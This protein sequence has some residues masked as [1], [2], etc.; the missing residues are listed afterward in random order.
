MPSP[1]EAALTEILR[2][3]GLPACNE[4]VVAAYMASRGAYVREPNASGF[5]VTLTPEEFAAV[6]AFWSYGATRG[7]HTGPDGTGPSPG[8]L[9]P[10]L[11]RM[12]DAMRKMYE[13]NR[14]A[15]LARGE[16]AA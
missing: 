9:T 3:F 4:D 15:R 12:G 6:C 11:D 16:A 13:A 2:E 7:N 1:T 8:P 14:V 10:F 5:T